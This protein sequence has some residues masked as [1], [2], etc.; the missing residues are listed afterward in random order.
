MF[1]PGRKMLL[2]AQAFDV[3]P[4]VSAALVSVT[5]LM[6]SKIL[7]IQQVTEVTCALSVANPATTEVVVRALL[8]GVVMLS[9]GFV[10]SLTM[11]KRALAL[12][13]LCRKF[14]MMT[15]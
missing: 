12:V 6:P 7:V 1:V 5:V 13:T 3:P 2:T 8:A 11:V 4:A 9:F 14:V 10:L 15:L